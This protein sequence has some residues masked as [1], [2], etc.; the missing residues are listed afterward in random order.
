M[1]HLKYIISFLLLISTASANSFIPYSPTS[2]AGSDWNT[3][4]NI[5]VFGDGYAT[6]T[7][8]GTLNG[9]NYNIV[10]IP[11]TFTMNELNVS[12]YGV[13]CDGCTGFL[14]ITVT[15]DGGTTWAA[16][17]T[18]PT[19]GADTIAYFNFAAATDWTK[20]KLSNANFKVRV[21]APESGNLQVVE[22]LPVYLNIST[23][24]GNYSLDQTL[25]Y[26]NDSSGFNNNGTITG[27]QWWTDSVNGTALFFDGSGDYVTV[28]TSASLN[29]STITASAWVKFQSNGEVSFLSK[30]S[31]SYYFYCNVF[32]CEFDGTK[33]DASTFASGF[34][35]I[36]SNNTW[37]YISGV[38]DG[39][40]AYIYVNGVLA[41]S[42]S[43]TSSGIAS[44][45]S[46]LFIGSY[47]AGVF[48]FKGKIDEVKVY[49]YALNTSERT[50]D[51]QHFHPV[52]S[53]P[54]NIT[55]AAT[56]PPQTTTINF[57]WHDTEY[58]ADEIIVARDAAFNLIVV[59]D[60]VSTDYK[61]ANLDSG[62]QYFWKVR[63]YNGTTGTYGDTSQVETFT[64][65]SVSGASG[66][67][68]EGIIYELIGGIATPVTGATVYIYNST[69]SN[70]QITGSNGYYLFSGLSNDTYNVY[71]L[72][73]N[74]DTTAAFPVTVN[75]S[76]TQN[77]IL[78]KKTISPY[79]PNFVY[80]KFTVRGLFG[81]EFEGVTVTVF[82]GDSQNAMFTATTDSAGQAVFQ[83]I[84]D[85]KY[86][87]TFTGGGLSGTLTINI[88]G[89]EE[90]YLV[91]V[92]GGFPSGGDR[93]SDITSNLTAITINS[94][95]SNLSL[96][97]NDTTSSTSLIWFYARN[98]ST[99]VTCYQTNTADVVT[100]GCPVWASGSYQF[101]FNS[102]SST[103]GFF[104][105]DKIIN[106]DAGHTPGSGKSAM[107]PV[108]PV[109]ANT[110]TSL[111]NWGAVAL[112]VLIGSLFSVKSVKHGAV[113]VPISAM[114]F[115]AAGWLNVS[116]LILSCAVVI[117]IMYYMR[118]SESKV[119]L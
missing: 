13:R 22:Y 71:A 109:P 39:Q 29:V 42:S 16:N 87:L 96:V 3:P 108:N 21:M 59:D 58:P 50:L 38:Y 74:Y 89:K 12:L 56:Y 20:T 99:N 24:V 103:Y 73:Q 19:T 117:G 55:I 45:V 81:D 80:E 9:L 26:A 61:V 1:A 52:P 97:Y 63:Q 25:A 5:F 76:I 102:T 17:Q 35:P 88:Y 105:H 41:S 43:G 101:G 111:L 112:I 110:D 48:D 69:W 75:G 84:K 68:I 27:A 53:Y 40:T 79:V 116:F 86:R 2:S 10:N 54:T 65:G 104:H 94:T 106:F 82:E 100:L 47:A 91:T 95:W 77:N 72:K 46:N 33:Q 66:R 64:I 6:K 8:G 67:G 28:P 92:V 34:T 18:Y 11:E 78:I 44:S 83:L 119:N 85:Q 36:L 23:I 70:L 62:L 49:N 30:S 51:Y 113:V 118:Q 93:N 60:F 32:S 14:N 4:N 7:G 90:N 115:W 15:W 98:L 114:I 57:T 37:Y 31:S 107:I